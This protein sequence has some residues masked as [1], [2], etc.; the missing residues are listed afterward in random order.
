MR[1]EWN[2]ACPDWEQRLAEGRSLIPDLPLFEQ[3][4]EDAVAFFDGLHLFDVPGMPL[5]RDACR[6]WF[7]DIVRVVLGSRDPESN[8]RYVPELLAMIPKGNAKTTYS[9]LLM[10]TALLVNE[11]PNARFF[12]IAP[13]Q[14]TAEVAF[15]A[16]AGA[17]AQD[18]ELTNRFHPQ[19][20]LGR[21]TD[22]ENGSRLEIKTFSLEILN[23]PKPVGVL[24]DEI[25]LLAKQPHAIKILRQIRGGLQK[26][27]EG[28]LVITTTQSNEP[29]QGIFE[30]E[31][32]TAR[33]IRDGKMTGRMLPVLYEF[34]EAIARDRLQWSNPSNWHMV[35][36]NLGASLRLETLVADWEQEQEKGEESIRLWASQHLNIQIGIGMGAAA[37]AGAE[38]WER[39][40]DPTLT[41]DALLTRSEVVTIGVDGGGLD[42]LLG[43]CVLGRETGT[44]K[45]LVWCKAWV[46]KI[47]LA[48]RKEIAQKLQDLAEA[49]HLVIVDDESDKDLTEV[50]DI[51]EKVR[52]AG[53]LPDENAIGADPAGSN[54]IVDAMVKRGF[55][56][57][58]NEEFGDIAQ[59]SQGYKLQPAFK[60]AEIR[61]AQGTLIHDASP[62]MAWCVGNAKA[63]MKGNGMMITKQIA[64][65]AK[66]DPVMAMFNAV[67]LM[68]L[69]PEAS[70]RSFWD[71][72]E[73]AEAAEV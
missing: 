18:G 34:P 23:G 13:S 4:A 45:W 41:L 66:I 69:N 39:R 15:D 38:F 2:F 16:V 70:G 48:R 47:A 3:E 42:D 51:M 29:P 24:L 28:F 26:N 73:A 17:I 10:L 25:H 12:L 35:M 60:S 7:R 55:N 36:P 59:V 63:E 65:Y 71:T 46:H 72:D 8:I 6:D 9:A 11:R 30:S 33:A 5:M 62:L 57:G 43:L 64:G 54:E 61:L 27:S 31:L 68:A 58:S 49:G 1:R 37:W 67:T 53:L 14:A 22:R 19:A 40:S 20:H 52:D 56:V 21:I 44:R 32:K 50:V